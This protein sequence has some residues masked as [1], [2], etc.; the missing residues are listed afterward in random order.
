MNWIKN[1]YNVFD[2]DYC[3]N[4]SK[5]LQEVPPNKCGNFREKNKFLVNN[6]PLYK[7]RT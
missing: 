2:L 6:Y 1:K 5:L 4:K 7:S 3:S